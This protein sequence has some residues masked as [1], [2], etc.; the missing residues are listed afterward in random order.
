MKA[1]WL[2]RKTED[3]ARPLALFCF[4]GSSGFVDDLIMTEQPQAEAWGL[5]W[6]GFWGQPWAAC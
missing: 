6:K 3:E 4:L 5:K 2:E 1:L